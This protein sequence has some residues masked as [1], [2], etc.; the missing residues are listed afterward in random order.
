MK[1]NSAIPA[2]ASLALADLRAGLSEYYGTRLKGLRLY[3]SMA[4]GEAKPGSDMD[5]LV[6]LDGPVDAVEEITRTGEIVSD[7]SRQYDVAIACVFMADGRFR[8]D[9]GPFVRNVRREGIAV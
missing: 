2:H 1:R 9:G 7:V 4:R 6:L 5:V 8:A 3:G